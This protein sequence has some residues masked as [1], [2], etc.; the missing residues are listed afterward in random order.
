[1]TKRRLQWAIT[2]P[3]GKPLL[4]DGV[5]A[6]VDDET[7]AVSLD[8]RAQEVVAEVLSNNPVPSRSY[9]VPGIDLAQEVHQLIQDKH[10]AGISVH[11]PLPAKKAARSGASQATT[12]VSTPYDEM[13]R[14]TLTAVHSQM[15]YLRA[16][17]TG[18]TRETIDLEV[19]RQGCLAQALYRLAQ[20][21]MADGRTSSQEYFALVDYLEQFIGT[22]LSE[23]D[24]TLFDEMVQKARPHAAFV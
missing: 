14:A 2:T 15:Q 8:Q 6:V 19:L 16:N 20:M 9:L 4:I 3:E 5:I 7:G 24:R 23:K 11:S 10:E 13:I 21:A 12:I 1:M 17:L 22:M 18:E